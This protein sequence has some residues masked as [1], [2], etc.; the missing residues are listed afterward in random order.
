MPKLPKPLYVVIAAC[1]GLLGLGLVGLLVA[2]LILAPGLPSVDVLKD[3]HLQVPLRIY[4]RDGRLLAVYGEKR[5]IPLDYA[6]IP[7]TMVN[8]FVAAE[9]E[10]FWEHPGVD[11]EGMARAAVHYA[12]TGERTQ[13]GGTITMQ[14]ARNFFLTPE[15]TFTRKMREVFL[16]FRIEHQLSKQD[17]MALY[18]NKIYLGSH[19]YGVGAAAEAY[20]GTDVDHLTLAQTAMIAGLPKGPST[21]NPLVNPDRALARRGYVLGRMLANGYINQQQ[22]GAA[23]AEPDD[24]SYH[25]PTAEV[26][27]PY[28]AEMVRNYMVSKYGDDAYNAGYSVVTTIDSRLQPLAAKAVREGLLQYDQRHGWRGPIAHVDLPAN[29]DEDALEKVLEDRDHVGGLYPSVVTKVDAQSVELYAEGAGPVKVDWNGIKWARKFL[30]V[31]SMGPSPKTAADV[32]AKGDIVYLRRLEAGWSL[33]QVPTAQGALVSLDPVDGAVVALVGGFDYDASK[34][35]RVMQSHRQPGSS[36]KP[37]I[38][39][40]ALENGF[41]AAT[42]V[43]NLPVVVNDP[44]NGNVWRPHNFEGDFSGPTRLRTALAHSL[45]LVTIRVL[46]QLGIDNVIKY[47]A[48]FGFTADELPHDLTMALGSASLEPLEMARGY[49]VFANRGYLVTP[50]FIQKVEDGDG[51]VLFQADPEIACDSCGLTADKGNPDLGLPAGAPETI[52]PQN[53]WLMT[54]LMQEVIKSGTG[55]AAQSLNRPD[56]A[57][58]TGTSNDYTD[59]WFDGFS[60]HLVTVVWVGNDQP[61]QTLGDGEQGALAALPMWMD[62]VGPAMHGVIIPKDIFPRPFGIEEARIDP[63]TG[64]LVSADDPN[65]IFEF[66]ETGHLPAKAPDKKK[67]TNGTDIF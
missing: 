35:N 17:I 63:D 30:S 55:V 12:T 7:Q 33:A 53:A 43:P 61:S 10:H 27:A 5:R 4:T 8:A 64:L 32:L 46:Q 29:A 48:N 41:T 3:I 9:D 22:Y 62:Y 49:A 25:E 66:F 34:F 26:D 20:Y 14:L 42:V 19:A 11:M 67:T 23:M 40:P 56:I 44:K 13:G 31:D 21:D 16:A 51:K 39:S 50:Y 59:A 58:K 6:Q 45:N 60:A 2:Y 15:K 57:G 47:D 28:L 18:L 1:S 38:Y 36:F 52:T 24:A 65:S 37:F 54:S